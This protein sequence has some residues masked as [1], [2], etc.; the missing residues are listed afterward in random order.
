MATKTEAKT[1]KSNY[2]AFGTFTDKRDGKMYKT[3]KIGKQVWM[4]ENLAYDTKDKGSKCYG[5]GTPIGCCIKKWSKAEIQANCEKYGRL[6]YWKTAKKACPKGWHIPSDK[7]WQA[8]VK[9]AGGKEKAG[10]KL[11]A[12][13]GWED[14]SEGKSG[15]GTDDF[16]FAAMPGGIGY[17][18]GEFSNIGD[19]GVWWLEEGLDLGINNYSINSGVNDTYT[20]CHNDDN[21]EY[22]FS[23]RCIKD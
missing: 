1:K 11:K 16:G 21:S 15:N 4:A 13:D 5:E 23:I 7:D 18:S 8:L 6:Y 17:S 2:D 3:V 22:L 14:T 10:K 9:F 12:K 20:F 19:S